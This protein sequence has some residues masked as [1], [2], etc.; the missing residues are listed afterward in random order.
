MPE[1]SLTIGD[2][3]NKAIERLQGLREGSAAIQDL[4]SCGQSAV[5]PLRE[6]LFARNPSGIYQPR[7]DAVQALA[8]LGAKDVLLDFL[9]YPRNVIDPTE[10]AGEDAVTN[11]VAR[12]L[13]NWPDDQVFSLLLE[14]SQHK[15]LD[16]V[17]EALAEYG[18]EEAIPI[19]ASALGEDF[20][21]PAAEKAFRKMGVSSCPHLLQLAVHR[22]VADDIEFDSSRR[23][24]RSALRLFAELHCSDDLPENVRLLIADNDPQ[25]ALLAC[26]ICLPRVF[27]AERQKIAA[28]LIILLN[29]DDWMLRTEVEDLLIHYYADCRSEI[30]RYITLI[31]DPAAAS[32]RRI[33]SQIK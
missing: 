7:C 2:R 17:V 30:E 12:A 9:A 32:L 14:I 22:K 6:F 23:C 31:G 3:I 4:V 28:R 1:S 26:S 29:T 19:F 33:M 20:C 24:R 27:P 21:R 10:Q 15:L 25:V 16:G 8:A 18:R 5:G 13:I 11:A